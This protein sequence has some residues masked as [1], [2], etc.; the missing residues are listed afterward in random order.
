MNK[1]DTNL[2][3]YL[4]PSPKEM[5]ILSGF[6]S[7]NGLSFPLEIVKKY[8][9]LFDYFSLD[10][11]SP[12][13][14]VVFE[15]HSE[16]PSEGYEIKADTDRVA[17]FFSDRR[18]Q[19]Y[20]VSTLLQIVKES[21]GIPIPC[22]SIRDYPDLSFRGFHLDVSRG[23]VPRF[24]IL[25]KL[26]IRL[27][28]LKFNAVSLY[29][30]DTV[31]PPSDSQSN[32]KKSMLFPWEIEKLGRVLQRLG[33]GFFPSMQTLCH[34]RNWLQRPGNQ[35]H[36]S[37]MSEDC[38]D[39]ENSEAK[40][41]IRKYVS[42]VSAYFPSDLLNIGMD[43]CAALDSPELYS[44]YFQETARYFL[45]QGKKVAVWGD[46][47]LHYRELIR[48]IPRDVLVFNWD[49][50]SESEEDFSKNVEPFKKHHIPQV[51]CPATWSWAKMIPSPAR[52]Y[53][54]IEAAYKSAKRNHLEGVLLTSWGDD[55]NEYLLEGIELCLFF[56]GNLL[57]S[58]KNPEPASF[59]SWCGGPKGDDLFRIYTF[60][61]KID[62][63]LPYTHRYYLWEDPLFAPYSG[64]Q[65]PAVIVSRFRKFHAYLVKR[66]HFTGRIGKYL[67]YVSDLCAFIADKVD[68]SHTFSELLEQEN[69]AEVERSANRLIRALEMLKSAY[70]RLWLGEYKP[71][72]LF[73]NQ[74]KFTQ[75]QERF[76][77]FL[78][79]LSDAKSLHDFQEV[80]KH[81]F[82]EQPQQTVLFSRLF[83][84]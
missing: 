62:Q 36:S 71:E 10:S 64:E 18:G 73:Y 65:D 33:I 81:Y 61:T 56:T 5:N 39:A 38:I 43:E 35:N 15:E 48:T 13:V 1:M 27:V 59:T 46:M 69:V 17:V 54:N 49:Y 66:N 57:W 4:Y 23:A 8:G 78:T 76:R 63:P 19:L 79:M 82:M 12:G 67:N 44:S 50:F 25:E 42:S 28:L 31:A 60:L 47:F 6:L 14:P 24:S 51:L 75:I 68:F 84:Q 55:G 52:A 16:L 30:E 37:R 9:V 41:A 29:I 40:E 11:S 72:G 74:M 32:F 45:D 22:F 53:R 34:L 3:G 58:G 21:E 2:F 70:G 26:C 20:G 83:D 7:K 77:F 80:R